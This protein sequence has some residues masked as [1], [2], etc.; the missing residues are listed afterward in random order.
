[1]S[2]LSFNDRFLKLIL[3]DKAD[4]LQENYPNAFLLLIQIAKQARRTNDLMDGLEIGDAIIG[5]IETSKK[6]GLSKK[7]YRN[8]LAKLE[9]IGLVICVYNQKDKKCQKRAIKRAIKSKIVNLVDSSICD[10]NR[11]DRGEQN[12][13]LGANK[14]RTEGDKQERI[15]KKEKEKDHQPQTPSS[16]DPIDA[17]VLTDDFSFS[18]KSEEEAKKEIMHQQSLQQS[19]SGSQFKHAGNLAVSV[20]EIN[21]QEPK[22]EIVPGIFLTQSVLDKCIQIKGSLDAV[23]NAMRYIQNCPTRKAEIRDWPNALQT[24]TIKVDVASM[25]IENE[26]LAIKNEEKYNTFQN[27]WKGSCYH[28]RNKDQKGFL[29]ECSNSFVAPVFYAYADSEFLKKVSKFIE[30]NMLG[31][32]K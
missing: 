11:M 26:R 18:L 1:M 4:S 13:E 7:E 2:N 5:E 16:P 19:Y 14:G 23:Q 32:K 15:R 22:T 12:G 31:I 24:W 8:A 10:I 3:S 6:A 9:E 20:L 17:Q 30:T 27:G 21:P 28:D 25:A 29:F